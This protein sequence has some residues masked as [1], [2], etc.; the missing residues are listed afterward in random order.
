MTEINLSEYSDDLLYRCFVWFVKNER[1]TNSS[2]S[3]LQQRRALL[4][5][6]ISACTHRPKLPDPVVFFRH[7]RLSRGVYLAD[8]MR[9]FVMLVY[10]RMEELRDPERQQTPTEYLTELEEWRD[11]LNGESNSEITNIRGNAITH[12]ARKETAKSTRRRPIRNR[13]VLCP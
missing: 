8:D 5:L 4:Q 12:T 7:R 2:D 9:S 10:D 13:N 11:S 6:I 1:H 3:A